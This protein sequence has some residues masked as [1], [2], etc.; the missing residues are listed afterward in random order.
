MTASILASGMVLATLAA[1]RAAVTAGR[2]AGAGTRLATRAGRGRRPTMSAPS[3]LG[4]RLHAAGVDL[5]ANIAWTA[6]LAVAATA[7]V[8]SLTWGGPGLA[9]VTAGVAAGAPLVAWKAFRHRGQAR[10]EAALPAAVEAVARGLRSGAS[11]RQAVA[12]AAGSAAGD[13]RR[14][15]IEVAAATGHGATLTDSLEDW[16]RRRPL[17]GVR[18]VVAAL[19]L[20]SEMGGATAQAVDGVADTLRQRLAVAAEARALATQAR[21]S[22]TVIALAPVAFCLVASAADP[23]TLS[24]V[25][26]TGPGLAFLTAGLLLDGLGALWMAR[27]TRIDP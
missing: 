27:I 16:A 25:F 17:P 2:S 1:A 26:R 5:D 20:A 10:F 18:L 23:R 19:C 21:A 13:L 4:G 3:W 11:L 15:L 22:A 14:D 6:W 9:A 24:F 8:L 7:V 12:E